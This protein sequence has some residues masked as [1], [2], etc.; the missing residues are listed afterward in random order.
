MPW[1][2][3]T[4]RRRHDQVLTGNSCSTKLIV[5]M[6]RTVSR[7]EERAMLPAQEPT[8]CRSIRVPTSLLAYAS[9]TMSAF[10]PSRGQ[11]GQQFLQVGHVHI[12]TL[13]PS[14]RTRCARAWPEASISFTVCST[15]W[16]PTG[17]EMMS[18]T[19]RNPHGHRMAM[20]SGLLG[21]AAGEDIRRGT[22][23]AAA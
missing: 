15:A 1:A 12:T 23:S 6:V 16:C 20:L 10:R 7:W 2:H 19:P 8:A 11:A 4:V 17:E 9:V 18:V 3:G 21:A 5:P 22:G 14:N 13:P